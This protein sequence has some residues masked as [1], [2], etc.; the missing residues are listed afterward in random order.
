MDRDWTEILEKGI[1]GKGRRHAATLSLNRSTELTGDA[2]ITSTTKVNADKENEAGEGRGK[3][4]AA[5]IVPSMEQQATTSSE[6][7]EAK[8]TDGVWTE[9][10]GKGKKRAAKL[11]LVR[12]T[13]PK[14]DL[15]IQSTTKDDCLSLQSFSSNTCCTD[16]KENEAGEGGGKGDKGQDAAEIVPSM[17][18]QTT[19]SSEKVEAKETDGV[20]TEILGKGKK[21]A[22]KLLLVRSTEPKKDLVIQ[23]TTKDD[24]LSLQSFSSNTCCTDGKENEAGDGQDAA[25]IVPSMEHQATTSSE[26]EEEKETDGVWT[27]I[28]GKGRKRALKI[29]T[30]LS[31]YDA[32]KP[33][34]TKDNSISLQSLSN[35]CCND[36]KENKAVR[37]DNGHASTDYSERFGATC[38][39]DDVKQPSIKDPGTVFRFDNDN[40]IPTQEEVD[41]CFRSKPKLCPDQIVSILLRVVKWKKKI[42]VNILSSNNLLFVTSSLQRMLDGFNLSQLEFATVGTLECLQVIPPVDIEKSGLCSF[43]DQEFAI[44]SNHSRSALHLLTAVCPWNQYTLYYQAC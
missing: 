4:D 12:S 10:L 1:L 42:Q 41:K 33:S 11:L 14:K 8:E 21:R 22:A 3:G 2:V 28:L 34:T 36:G 37:R 9:I 25:E 44:L 23:S 38:T 30:E 17:E 29:S 13:E 7:V 19:T 24:C 26:K 5:Q 27:E 40:D 43:L 16:G 39:T 15:V 35:T 32:V 31:G 6:K 20:W 18:Q